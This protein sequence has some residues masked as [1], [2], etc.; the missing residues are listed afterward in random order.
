MDRPIDQGMNREQIEPRSS[1]ITAESD[2][3][4]APPD[5]GFNR[6]AWALPYVAG[7]TGAALA[8][9]VAYRWTRRP[10]SR[11]T[12]RPERRCAGRGRAC[13]AIGR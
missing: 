1:P 9:L 13:R 11:R 6:L 12:G 8:G 10:G 4:T 5:E 2:V 3:L 7:A